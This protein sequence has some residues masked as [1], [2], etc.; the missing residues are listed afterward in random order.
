[1][2]VLVLC[3]ATCA[4]VDPDVLEVGIRCDPPGPWRP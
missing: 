2:K 4:A 3:P 1:M